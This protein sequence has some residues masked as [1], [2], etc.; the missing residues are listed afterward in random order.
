MAMAAMIHMI[1]RYDTLIG[2]YHSHQPDVT[3]IVVADDLEHL[4]IDQL[5]CL[6]LG[7]ASQCCVLPRP[8]RDPLHPLGQ[9]RDHLQHQ[10]PA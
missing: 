4:S 1:H 9:A 6:I 3:V 8:G 2:W 7:I 5:Q 10:L